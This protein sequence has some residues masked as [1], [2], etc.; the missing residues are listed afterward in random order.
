TN[1]EEKRPCISPGCDRVARFEGKCSRHGGGRLCNVT[2]CQ[3]LARKGG[4]CWRHGKHSVVRQ[5]QPTEFDLPV[6]RVDEPSQAQERQFLLALEHIRICTFTAMLTATA[7]TGT[8]EGDL[9][10]VAGCSG[11]MA[12]MGLAGLVGSRA[13]TRVFTAKWQLLVLDGLLALLLVVAGITMV[14][15]DKFSR[16]CSLQKYLQRDVINCAAYHA[17]AGCL[18]ASAVLYLVSLGLTLSGTIVVTEATHAD[19]PHEATPTV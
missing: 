16:V 12:A 11:W 14:A 15:T 13:I 6:A 17:S 1:P 10:L 5:M 9:G 18:F 8:S 7:I 4:R 3:K 19:Y 2:A